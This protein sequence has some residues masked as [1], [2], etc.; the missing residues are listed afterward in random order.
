[1]LNLSGVIDAYLLV[2]QAEG[3]SPRTIRRY[4]KVLGDFAN[5]IG[6]AVADENLRMFMADLASRAGKRGLVR[7]F[8]QWMCV[9]KFLTETY[10]QPPHRLRRL[11]VQA[12]R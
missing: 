12:E 5:S 1:M 9:Q 6:E 2:C 10:S 7:A 8:I 11:S 3:K 4:R